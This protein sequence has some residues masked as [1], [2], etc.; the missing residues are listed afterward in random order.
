MGSTKEQIVAREKV[1][2]EFEGAIPMTKALAGY[3]CRICMVLQRTREDENHY[4]LRTKKDERLKDGRMIDYCDILEGEMCICLPDHNYAH[5]D[6]T[7]PER[8]LYAEM[9]EAR[10][11]KDEFE[12]LDVVAWS[13]RKEI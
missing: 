11:P 10:L 9:L 13:Q 8:V 1:P 6:H 7:W 3:D 4:I 2:L 12:R 5:A